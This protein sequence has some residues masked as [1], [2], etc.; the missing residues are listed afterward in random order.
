[1]TLTSPITRLALPAIAA[2]LLALYGWVGWQALHPRVSDE[3]RLFYIDR[4]LQHWPGRDGLEYRLGD[5]LLLAESPRHLGEEWGSPRR[6]GWWH[7]RKPARVYVDLGETVA[8]EALFEA[9]V[10]AAPRPLPSGAAMPIRLFVNGTLAASVEY[11]PA[12]RDQMLV[13]RYD[14]D[15]LRI[16][17]NVLTVDLPKTT[18]RTVLRVRSLVPVR[19]VRHR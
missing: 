1:M 4:A 17:L 2:P 6:V 14:G 18:P 13:W 8:G 12:A 7:T 15:L 5:R 3:Y 16:G 19:P 10:V 9:E 11:A